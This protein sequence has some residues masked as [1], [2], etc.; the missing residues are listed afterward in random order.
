[1]ADKV[2]CLKAEHGIPVFLLYAQIQQTRTKLSIR[3]RFLSLRGG[4][5]L[6]YSFFGCPV[7]SFF[8]K[9]L[10]EA[11]VIAKAD[12]FFYQGQGAFGRC[13]ISGGNT[14]LPLQGQ[15]ALR[16]GRAQQA[17][18]WNAFEY[19][20]PAPVGQPR[21]HV[22]SPHRARRLFPDRANAYR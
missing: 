9:V 11:Q 2:L 4:Y 16:R 10:H 15:G 20:L 14:G 12:G 22:G 8:Q 19:L 21:T 17:L 7:R 3:V 6:V 1:M 18:L 13:H 5:A